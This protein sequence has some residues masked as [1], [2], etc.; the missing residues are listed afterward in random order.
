[1]KAWDTNFLIRHLLEDDDRQV[2][3]VRRELE[4]AV[5]SGEKVWLAQLVLVEA[6]WVLGAHLDKRP[7]LDTIEEVLADERFLV[8]DA[9]L[10]KAALRDARLKGDF[11]EHLIA[12]N[13]RAAGCAHTQ[14]F[15]RAVKRFGEFEVL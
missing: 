4:K 5:R 2:A 1:V 12:Q 10:V 14:T 8:Q 6:V 15:D 9:S 3:V 7:V 11:A 13:A